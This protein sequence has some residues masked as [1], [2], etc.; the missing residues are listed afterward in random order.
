M[1]SIAVYIQ[2]LCSILKGSKQKREKKLSRPREYYFLLLF[3]VFFIVQTLQNLCL[4]IKNT[5]LT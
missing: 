5:D 4:I 3:V 1:R 2:I